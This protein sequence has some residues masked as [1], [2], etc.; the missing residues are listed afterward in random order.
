MIMPEMPFAQLAHSYDVVI[1]GA[2][3]AGCFA[4]KMLSDDF[5]TL[6]IDRNVFPRSKPCGGML[7]RESVEVMKKFNP[8]SA[9]FT[10]P[11]QLLL[12]Y[13]D[14]DNGLES[15]TPRGF[16][17][18]SRERFDYWVFKL[19]RDSPA[20][21]ITETK[22]NGIEHKDGEIELTIRRD[23]QRKIRAKHLIA[24]DGHDSLVRRSLAPNDITKYLAIQ[25]IVEK[26][27]VDYATFIFDNS[28]T[29]FYSWVIPKRTHTVVGSAIPL[30]SYARF[31][32]F[33]RKIKDKLALK[34]SGK[35][36]A[37]IILRPRSEKEI[38]LG[39]GKILVTGEAGG[40]ISPSTGEGISYAIRSGLNSAEAINKNSENALE[41]YEKLCRPLVEEIKKKNEK[42][43]I[44]ADP[45]SRKEQWPKMSLEE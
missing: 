38:F 37:A 29:D 41:S 22:V 5:K 20:R 17:N 6:V 31:D 13:L 39:S 44:L 15:R 7:V 11:K 16:Y 34:T 32:L 19:M 30:G 26:N 42:A 23:H 24:A 28:I 2:G 1:V 27:P 33:K 3:P 45:K 8:D 4:A 40:L 35:V 21:Y 14:W 36:E 9:I 12:H 18:V 43:G 10:H 25:E